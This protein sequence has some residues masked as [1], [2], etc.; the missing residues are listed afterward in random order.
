MDSPNSNRNNIAPKERQCE[1]F[2]S[3]R[4]KEVDFSLI[5]TKPKD[6]NKIYD[7]FH[8]DI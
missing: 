1:P 7:A 4:M 8:E 5:T 3:N 2:H 6:I